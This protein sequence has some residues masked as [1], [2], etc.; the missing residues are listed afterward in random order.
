MILKSRAALADIANAKGLTTA[1]E[2]GTHQAVFAAEFL[3]RF[4]GTLT[5]I[6]P[7]E[8]YDGVR[9]V[10]YPMV[11]ETASRNEDFQIAQDLM[12]AKFLEGRYLFL[13]MRS[14][15]ATVLFDDLSVGFVYIDALHD[16]ESVIQDMRRWETKIVEG[17]IIAGHDFA[18]ENHGVI[19][20]V[21]EFCRNRSLQFHVTQED[22][23]SWWIEL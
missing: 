4:R 5:M 10:F 2:I 22:V 7:W 17:G 12:A 14:E 19:H 20:A 18:I 3:E 21:L 13:R 8:G 23:P 9:D 1:V 6:D 16:Y 15:E 11:Q